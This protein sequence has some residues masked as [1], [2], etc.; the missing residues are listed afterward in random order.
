M[1]EYNIF[2]LYFKLFGLRR[3]PTFLYSLHIIS[4]ENS[5]HNNSLVKS[6]SYNSQIIVHDLSLWKF[7]VFLGFFVNL[8]CVPSDTPSS[9]NSHKILWAV[10][11]WWYFEVITPTSSP[12]ML[13]CFLMNFDNQKGCREPGTKSR[14]FP[15]FKEL[16]VA[17]ID[18]KEKLVFIQRCYTLWLKKKNL[19]LWI[20][21]QSCSNLAFLWH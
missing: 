14:K 4:I 12:V 2:E 5:L 19:H 13:I 20:F 7:W 3:L 11:I 10:N 6:R 21:D 17:T 1:A 9:L 15:F 18:K 16:C 8:L